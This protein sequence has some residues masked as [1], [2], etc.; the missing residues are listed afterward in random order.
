MVPLLQ[1]CDKVWF[2]KITSP[3]AKK[4]K[5]RTSYV[6]KTM[7]MMIIL[8]DMVGQNFTLKGEMVKME[9]T[10]TTD[11]TEGKNQVQKA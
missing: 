4:Y 2:K 8:W 10:V 5:T 1:V 3:K 6:R 11:I 7:M 9:S